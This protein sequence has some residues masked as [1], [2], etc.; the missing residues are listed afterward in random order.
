MAGE[1]QHPWLS[2]DFPMCHGICVHTLIYEQTDTWY[3]HTMLKDVAQLTACLEC[4]RLWVPSPA[5]HKP[6]VVPYTCN[7]KVGSSHLWIHSKLKASL[8]YLRLGKTK[9]HAHKTTL[10]W[11]KVLEILA[12]WPFFKKDFLC[13]CICVY[14]C[15]CVCVLLYARYCD[16]KTWVWKRTRFLVLYREGKRQQIYEKTLWLGY[17]WSP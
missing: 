5:Q 7:L 4:P 11:L 17:T 12:W 15:M 10:F 2:S 8:R 1:D 13:V 3:I 6:G 16:K 14:L 9:K